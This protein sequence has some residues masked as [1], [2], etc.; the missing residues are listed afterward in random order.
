MK[1]KIRPKMW[2]VFNILSYILV[3][4]IG[5][6]WLAWGIPYIDTDPFWVQAI[7]TIFGAIFFSCLIVG[8]ACLFFI[9]KIKIDWRENGES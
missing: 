5:C 4:V 2:E 9:G 7:V 3:T 1:I 8:L 6:M